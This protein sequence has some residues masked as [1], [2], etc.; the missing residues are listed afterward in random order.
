MLRQ[1]FL[2]ILIFTN[3]IVFSA[4][5]NV[6][7]DSSAVTKRKR[8]LIVLP[9][10]IKSPETKLGF[11]GAFSFLFRSTKRDTIVRTSNVE[12][13][14]LYTLNHQQV[15]VLSTN[16]YFP[17]E[18]YIFKST[19]SMSNF[20][21]KF[22]GL[23]DYSH[24]SDKEKYTYHQFLLYQQL[25]RRVYKSFYAGLLYEFQNV[26]YFQYIKDG[27]F[28]R[29]NVQGRNGSIVS[30]LGIMLAWDRRNNAFSSTKGSF[31]QFTATSFNKLIGSQFSFSTYSLD[32]R[33]YLKTIYHQVIAFQFFANINSGNTPV[34]NLSAL[35][36][37]NIMRG[38]Y[39]GRYRDKDL[40]A[41]QTEY[42]IP[43]WKRIGMVLFGGFGEVSPDIKRF[44]VYGLKYSVGGGL[45]FALKEQERLN[46]RIDYGIGYHSSGFYLI[47]S[48]A[49]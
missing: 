36:G 5:S 17:K 19:Y 7:A 3:S 44:S 43:V 27:I 26:Y 29:E 23:G 6:P 47:A 21:D 41:F 9:A 37:S 16:I 11:G 32:I 28:D 25:Q 35:G 14:G 8:K 42:R 40:I 22:W 46:L 48:E 34:R 4:A 2:F 31:V 12:G 49:F 33:K 18:K 45:R 30:G 39:A 15:N 10:I 13:L 20:P 24:A 38:Y 1:F